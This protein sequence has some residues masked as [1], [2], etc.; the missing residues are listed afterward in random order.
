MVQRGNF[1]S[2]DEIT[3]SN[4]CLHSPSSF[5]RKN[6]LYIQEAGTLQSL[7][8]HKCVR[9]NL[10]SFLI[11]IVLDG[12]GILE[13]A[14][15]N[16]GLSKGDCVWIDCM[17]HY[18][19]FSDKE[20]AWRL[21]WVHFNG[22]GARSIYELFLKYNQ[23]MNIVTVLNQKEIEGIIM[24]LREKQSEKN[25]LAELDCAEL[26]LHLINVIFG[27]V[28]SNIVMNS[29]FERQT[30]GEL[31][32]FINDHYIENGLLEVLTEEFSKSIAELDDIFDKEYGITLEEYIANRRYNAAK[33]LLRFSVK[34][35][36]DIARESGIG[37][38]VLMQN[39]FCENEGM[40]AEEYRQRWAGWVR[41]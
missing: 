24:E 2:T 12:K 35:I 38:M 28:A 31:R 27:H 30:A 18:E 33:E 29:D 5:A 15:E 36:A 3:K 37:D 1:S 7:Q 16:F 11:M 4:R 23:N 22:Q 34:P 21:A 39:L 25:P 19:H 41:N 26:L 9:E 14:G 17:Q 10:D 6:L 13:I 20:N 8:P 32:N 40:S